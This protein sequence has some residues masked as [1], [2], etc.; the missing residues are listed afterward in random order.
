MNSQPVWIKS[1]IAGKKL[2]K[3]ALYHL[4]ITFSY[5]CI[6]SPCSQKNWICVD[7]YEWGIYQRK[8]SPHLSAGWTCFFF[9]HFS[10]F[11][12]GWDKLFPVRFL[13]LKSYFS[14]DVSGRCALYSLVSPFPACTPHELQE[15][16]LSFLWHIVLLWFILYTS[17][18]L[19]FRAFL[20]H[21]FPPP[22]SSCSLSICFSRVPIEGHSH[23]H[24]ETAAS[25]SNGL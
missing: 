23:A 21:P 25:L 16:F 1:D 12:W 8:S 20:S 17:T 5:K 22:R 6:F 18:S 24:V 15:T 10:Y 13:T 3:N 14:S 2:H 11:H 19:P 9:Y 4:D 7:F